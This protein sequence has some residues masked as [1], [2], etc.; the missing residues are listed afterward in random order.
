MVKY[1]H[2]KTLWVLAFGKLW[3]T[4]SYFGT[5]TI[6]ALYF[7][8]IFHLDRSTSYVLYG[9]YA[10][11]AFS[12]PIIGGIVADRWLGSRK[13]MGIGLLINIVGN[14]VMVSLNHYFFCL[15][16]ATSIVGA[17]LYKSNSTNLV[18]TIYKD[19]DHNKESGFTWF[20]LAMNLGG[21]LGPL[22]YG[23]V[24]HYYGWNYAFIL[25][26]LGLAIGGF[27]LIKNWSLFNFQKPISI[28]FLKEFS[29]YIL[30]G[31]T[32]L[33]ISLMFYFPVLVSP[34]ICTIFFLALVYL[35]LSIKSYVGKERVRL[36]A[37]VIISFIGMFYFAAGLQTGTTVTLFIQGEIKNG[38][39]GVHL[40][41][42][43]FNMLYCLFVILL[44]PFVSF[45]WLKLR[46]KGISYSTPTKLSIGIALATIGIIMFAIASISK[47]VLLSIV[48][49]YLFLSAGELVLSP[50]AY[51]AISNLSPKGMKSSMMGCW[52]LFIAIGGYF[53]SILA[54][55][56][57]A[58][59]KLIPGQT[60]TYLD[61]FLTIG[62][63]T[64]II[65]IISSVFI[66]KI[67]RMME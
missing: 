64:L 26:A 25:S 27:W 29:I 65:A 1:K 16:L 9:A 48:I 63:F 28:S 43:T 24:A 39:I 10:A 34:F 55:A 40:P 11:L 52:L 36:I 42:S 61:V 54:N 44:A 58:V 6:L 38:S 19:N 8:H 41:G 14:L 33:I 20:Y 12:S 56:S 35:F 4:F 50:A 67:K 62:L 5:Q 37:A 17:G 45:L 7:M 53:S 13:S 60:N 2:P 49:G 59:V 46:K 30:I 18:G 57:H 31:L 15:G 23:L 47:F 3:D 21:T 22:T 51:T 32:I 66:K